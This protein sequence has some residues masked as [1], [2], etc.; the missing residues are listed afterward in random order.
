[1]SLVELV[2]ECNTTKF[3][4][5][6]EQE[7]TVASVKV[8][9]TRLHATGCPFKKH[10][11]FFAWSMLDALIKRSGNRCIGWLTACQTHRCPREFCSRVIHQNA[12]RF[13]D[14][15]AILSRYCHITTKADAECSCGHNA[16]Y[17][18]SHLILQVAVFGR[19]GTNPAAALVH[20]FTE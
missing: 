2:N 18:D 14:G 7:Q 20:S 6:W 15:E 1:M 13:E 8:F 3:D 5:S 12:L 17:L 4:Q 9:I 16:I 10:K 11:R 19:R